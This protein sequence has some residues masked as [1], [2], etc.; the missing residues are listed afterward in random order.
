MFTYTD[1]K[2]FSFGITAVHGAEI[3]GLYER[4]CWPMFEVMNFGF[5]VSLSCSQ[6][7]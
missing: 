7:T 5:A 1:K 4:Y 2:T 3:L 6:V